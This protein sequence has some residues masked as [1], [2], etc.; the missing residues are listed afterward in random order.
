MAWSSTDADVSDQQGAPHSLRAP[1][2]ALSL[3]GCSL[4]PDLAYRADRVGLGR[5]L[6]RPE[7]DNAG[8]AE[9][10][11]ARVATARLDTVERDLHDD[12]RA[13]PYHP[14]RLAAIS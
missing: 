11:A 2:R 12:V 4:R 14:E 13:D 7:P 6:V 3:V 9:G 8:E 10:Q 1:P 5:V